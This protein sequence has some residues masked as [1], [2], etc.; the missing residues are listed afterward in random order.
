MKENTL[1]SKF[2]GLDDRSPIQV[3]IFLIRLGVNNRTAKKGEWLGG[4]PKKSTSTN[5]IWVL[6]KF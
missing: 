6:L 4:Q 1:S 5:C 2:V 3:L